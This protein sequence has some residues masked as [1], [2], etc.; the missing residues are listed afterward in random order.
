MNKG[1]AR[2]GEAAGFRITFL[3]QVKEIKSTLDTDTKMELF[4]SLLFIHKII[5]SFAFKNEHESIFV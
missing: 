4:V 1:N 3:T 2:V 5:F